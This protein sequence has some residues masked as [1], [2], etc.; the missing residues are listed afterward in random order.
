MRTGSR[1]FP[2]RRRRFPR[3]NCR[4]GNTRALWAWSRSDSERCG[5]RVPAAR[6]GLEVFDRD[7][8][9]TPVP[10]FAAYITRTGEYVYIN[11]VDRQREE[12]R[13][14]SQT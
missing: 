1:L 3:G 10:Q 13:K 2:R 4:W 5:D 9:E 6:P 7:G 14:D 11:G 8:D 12:T